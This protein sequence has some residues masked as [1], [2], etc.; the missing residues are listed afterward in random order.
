[1]ENK[2]IITEEQELKEMFRNQTQELR[3][4]IESNQSKATN[5]ISSKDVPNYLGV[6]RKT[7]QNY[8]DKKLIPYSQ[9]GRIIRVKRSDL[10]AFIESGMI[11]KHGQ[12]S[13]F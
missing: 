8:R 12:T 2:L 6:S 4:L 13:K 1:M 5:W 11:G 3:Q 9:I 10:D 7:W